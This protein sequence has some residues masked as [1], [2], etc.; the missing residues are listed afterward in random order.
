MHEKLDEIVFK[1]M[2]VRDALRQAFR[3]D[4]NNRRHVL[5]MGPGSTYSLT[6]SVRLPEVSR[7]LAQQ[8]LRELL[9]EEAAAVKKPASGGPE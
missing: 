2:T 9:A 4:W 7:E 8:V 1:E 6:F 5:D 3:E